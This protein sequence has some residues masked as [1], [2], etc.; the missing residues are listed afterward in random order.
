MTLCLQV[1][2]VRTELPWI[3]SLS[4]MKHASVCPSKNRRAKWTEHV[5]LDL[6]LIPGVSQSDRR[7]VKRSESPESSSI[8]PFK[9]DGLWPSQAE[10]DCGRVH[11]LDRHVPPYLHV[12]CTSTC[13]IARHVLHAGMIGPPSRI[14]KATGESEVR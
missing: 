7:N 1:R 4:S 3:Q 2:E 8:P 13:T 5:S 12:L 9:S 14:R 10:L 11:M 6:S